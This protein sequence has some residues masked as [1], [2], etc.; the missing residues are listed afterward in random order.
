MF[1]H[2]LNLLLIF[3]LKF[4]YKKIDLKGG[5]WDRLSN[6]QQTFSKV[7]SSPI[8]CTSFGTVQLDYSSPPE[9]PV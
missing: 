2:C 4:S 8:F 3:L 1:Q 9:F 6:L 7:S 5:T